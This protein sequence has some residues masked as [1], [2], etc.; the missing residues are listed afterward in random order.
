MTFQSYLDTIYKK[1]GKSLEEF[2]M[3]ATEENILK[4]DITA[5]EFKDWLKKRFDLGPGHAMA[6]WKYFI[7]HDW[8][9][10]KHTTIK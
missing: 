10:T 4:D 6:L 9:K 5:T 3:L 2:R 1:T 7:D 8:I